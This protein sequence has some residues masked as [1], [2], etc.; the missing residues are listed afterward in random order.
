LVDEK[1]MKQ[2]TQRRYTHTTLTLRRR[3][4]PMHT[5]QVTVAYLRRLETDRHQFVLV[6]MT[7]LA[8][9]HVSPD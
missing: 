8:S 4:H 5:Y 1:C 3:L 9:V 2:I 7:A 6:I